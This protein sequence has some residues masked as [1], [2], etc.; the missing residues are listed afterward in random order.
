MCLMFLVFHF[1]TTSYRHHFMKVWTFKH[2]TQEGRFYCI[3]LSL[4]KFN[5]MTVILYSYFAPFIP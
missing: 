4:N 1:A 5:L 3:H 2:E